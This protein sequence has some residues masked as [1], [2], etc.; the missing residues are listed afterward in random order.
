MMGEF[1]GKVLFNMENKIWRARLVLETPLLDFHVVTSSVTLFSLQTSFAF[2]SGS[3]PFPL[4]LVLS[5]PSTR[6]LGEGGITDLL[7][8]SVAVCSSW[9]NGSVILTDA[10]KLKLR[11]MLFAG[12]FR[13]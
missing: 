12:N 6:L 13:Q 4:T 11:Q 8:C 2:F 5:F 9:P 10:G 3:F 1:V 7:F